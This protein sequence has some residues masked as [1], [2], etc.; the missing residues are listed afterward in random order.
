MSL[1]YSQP[2]TATDVELVRAFLLTY[3]V[4]AAGRP[5]PVQS[6]ALAHD[7]LDRLGQAVR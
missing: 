5:A 2:E 4:D 7:A 1:D 3:T 6:R